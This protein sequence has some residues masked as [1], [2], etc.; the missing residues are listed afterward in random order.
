MQLGGITQD[1]VLQTLA[2]HDRM[3]REA[4]LAAY[5]FR[6]AVKYTVV[7]Q[8]REYD[9]KAIA[10][11]AHKYVTGRALRPSQFSGGL[12]HAVAWLERVGFTVVPA[13]RAFPVRVGALRSGRSTSGVAKHRPLLLLW[14]FGQAVA[15]G[16]RLRPWSCTRDALAPLL[17]Q[18]G[19]VEDGVDGPV[20]RFG[21]CRVMGC[22][23]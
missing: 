21:R 10:G 11:V 15:G 18:F 20:I 4:F 1:A 19:E 22:G 7:H 8:G 2:E 3:G 5:G 9:S 13:H 17:E 23:R 16:S 6:P 12:G 14:A